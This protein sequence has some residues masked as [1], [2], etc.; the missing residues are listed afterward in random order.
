MLWPSFNENLIKT[1]RSFSLQEIDQGKS[2]EIQMECY[3]PPQ[4]PTGERALP[5]AEALG[6]PGQLLLGRDDVLQPSSLTAEPHRPSPVPKKKVLR[7]KENK[8]KKESGSC[9]LDRIFRKKLS[10]L[11]LGSSSTQHQPAW[12]YYLGHKTKCTLTHCLVC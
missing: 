4:G 7:T 12:L 6:Q 9:G 3:G 8:T 10:M 2:C 5:T 1:Y 11:T